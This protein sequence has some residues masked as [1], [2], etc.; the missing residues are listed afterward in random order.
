MLL[1]LIGASRA[2]SNNS[3]PINSPYP[4]SEASKNTLFS[5][6]DEQPKHL[7]PARSY[8]APEQVFISQIYEPPYQYNYLIRPYKL[9]P[10]SASEDILAEYYDNHNNKLPTA[11]TNK[12]AYTVYT[13]KIKQQIYYQPHPAFTRDINN[14]F[15]FHNLDKKTI[16]KFTSISDFDLNR[17]NTISTRELEAADFIYAIKR[18]SDPKIQ[19][20]IY[21]FMSNYIY[22]L[23]DINKL[24]LVDNQADK[25]I[26]LNDKK[27]DIDGLKLID[28]HTYQIK[29][30]GNYPQFIYWFAMNFF[31]PIAWEVDKFYSQEGLKA[32]NISMDTYPVGTG[33]YMMTV[34]K[35]NQQI[36]LEKNP[37]YNLKTL[38]GIY[39]ISG[40]PGDK[41]VGLLSKAGQKL[42]FID[43]VI[44]NL[45]KE[46]IP[47]WSKFL[48]GY[49]D[50]AGI[51]SD[52]FN[53]AITVANNNFGLSEEMQE[54]GVK[55]IRAMEPSIFYWGFNMLDPVVGGYT[56]K[57][58]KLR[59][60]I[61]IVFNVEE[62]INIFLNGRGKVA[63]D[64]VPPVIMGDEDKDK[65]LGFNTHVYIDKKTKKSLETAKQYLA[66]AGF[67]DGIDPKTGQQL[68]INFDAI[69]SGEADESALFNWLREQFQL[70]N[71]KLNIRATQY[72]RFQEKMRQG[73]AQMFF[74]GWSADYPDPENFLFLFLCKQG[75][76]NNN[77]EN[78]ANY[79][80][81]KFDKL[82]DQMQNTND[83]QAK[84]KVINQMIQ[85]LQDDS[86]WIFGL[87]TESYLLQHAWND[88]V[89]PLTIGNNNLKYRSINPK[90][91]VAYQIKNNQPITWPLIIFVL[92]IMAILLPVIISYYKK[93]RNPPSRI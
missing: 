53:Q 7:D 79:C 2:Y 78:A 65:G 47:V 92:V 32:Q 75:K 21:G 35:P 45:E 16:S 60:A 27:Y 37:N 15:L 36:V 23:T 6:Y 77:G 54:K 20:P 71:I 59:K 28:R 14:N 85:L 44:F 89:K 68:I 22:N 8:S 86:P 64:P 39:P 74:W 73:T 72:N 42:P 87:S 38:Q 13:I 81:Q 58:K 19:S 52:N 84:I 46:S 56:E 69:M 82:F 80:N 31:A 10:L 3:Y 34:N 1:L 93:T 12:I 40:M 49:Y 4:Y 18:L 29:I 55:L 26:N 76:V 50:S 63:H 62:Y 61:S 51:S 43:K 67:K 41:E 70:L 5:H 11:A 9:E 48:Q 30:K 57:Q 24:L 90:E 33:P 25:F 83:V 66:E 88:P 17:K 91:R